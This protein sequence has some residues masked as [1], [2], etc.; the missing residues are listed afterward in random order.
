MS[1]RKNLKGAVV[2]VVFSS[3]FPAGGWDPG[4][5]RQKD[6]VNDWF[7]GWCH[8]QGLGFYYLGHTLEGMGMLMLD[9]VQLTGWGS[10]KMIL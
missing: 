1:V 6:H 4:R 9:R 7:Q 10:G 8:A 5:R 3:V 2:Q